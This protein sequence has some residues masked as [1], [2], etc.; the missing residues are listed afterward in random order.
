MILGLKKMTPLGLL[1]E[2]YELE[3]SNC[4]H[5]LDAVLL[6]AD[7]DLLNEVAQFISHDWGELDKALTQT[8]GLRELFYLMNLALEYLNGTQTTFSAEQHE[9]LSIR[10]QVYFNNLLCIINS[11]QKEGDVAEVV[12]KLTAR[13][14][15][16]FDYSLAVQSD[17]IEQAGS[18]TINPSPKA[19][20]KMIL[21]KN[22]TAETQKT[23]REKLKIFTN[24]N[25]TQLYRDL[26]LLE[27]FASLP[28]KFNLVDRCNRFKLQRV[29]ALSA[30]CLFDEN[31]SVTE[32]HFLALSEDISHIMEHV[33]NNICSD[34][35]ISNLIE[36]PERKKIA[37]RLLSHFNYLIRYMKPKNVWKSAQ[38]LR[39]IEENP[40][41]DSHSIK[42]DLKLFN[43]ILNSYSSLMP[44]YMEKELID[45]RNILLFIYKHA[46]LRPLFHKDMTINEDLL[47]FIDE[48]GLEK[49]PSF[50]ADKLNVILKFLRT[51]KP[52]NAK[53]ISRL[54]A[55]VSTNPLYTIDDD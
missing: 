36:K 15:K 52:Q 43:K 38:G 51:V 18:K 53:L 7:V 49:L 30:S 55:R 16:S 25:F 40:A 48:D 37:T 19:L 23:S 31:F 46:E 26:C 42:N 24:L 39:A 32:D 8:G 17:L 20:L 54:E 14:A 13:M 3:Q 10:F 41:I 6:S 28:K 27:R 50:V 2:D 21:S 34:E 22:P 11:E 44:Y 12:E 45:I 33:N 4:V 1:L 9:E 29:M 35:E 47:S 5:G